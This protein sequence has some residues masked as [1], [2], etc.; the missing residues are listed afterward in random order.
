MEGIPTFALAVEE[1]ATRPRPSPLVSFSLRL[2][3]K[4]L[5][6]LDSFITETP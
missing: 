3:A 6:G 4:S 1:Q 2:W 5:M